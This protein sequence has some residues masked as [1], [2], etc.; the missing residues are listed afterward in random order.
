M[1]SSLLREQPG[2]RRATH[3]RRRRYW[4]IKKR[5]RG[6]RDTV[7]GDD[8]M[9]THVDQATQFAVLRPFILNLPRR[10]LG[11]CGGLMRL[12][13]DRSSSELLLRPATMELE[14]GNLQFRQHHQSVRSQSTHL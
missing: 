11:S 10:T 13:C 4:R 6:Y 14:V 7:F 8:P 3:E 2:P 1:R 9:R 5:L 12:P